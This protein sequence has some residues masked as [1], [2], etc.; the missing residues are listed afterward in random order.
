VGR[1]GKKGIMVLRWLVL[2]GN[3]GTWEP[4][5]ESSLQTPSCGRSV[6]QTDTHR[7]VPWAVCPCN[8]ACR[9]QREPCMSGGHCGV[10]HFP[11][12]FLRA[13]LSPFLWLWFQRNKG[14]SRNRV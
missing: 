3:C 14:K 11:V 12:H 7:W 8:M 4:Q 2:E 1:E 6:G 13:E 9:T 5:C 10:Q